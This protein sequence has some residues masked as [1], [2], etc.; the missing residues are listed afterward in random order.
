MNNVD[1]QFKLKEINNQIIVLFCSGIASQYSN[2]DTIEYSPGTVEEID[3]LLS[4]RNLFIEL[5][6]EKQND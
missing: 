3:N 5:L 1:L 6:K 2:K 4:K